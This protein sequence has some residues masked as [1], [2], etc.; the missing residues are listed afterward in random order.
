MASG[1]VLHSSQVCVG[2]GK[3]FFLPLLASLQG[4]LGH[5]TW[6]S[7]YVGSK[8]EMSYKTP[9]RPVFDPR[10]ALS[11]APVD[12]CLLGLGSFL[13]HTITWNTV[14]YLECRTTAGDDTSQGVICAPVS[15]LPSGLRTNLSFSI[16]I[17]ANLV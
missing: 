3:S 16:P 17:T 11:L 10:S 1:I 14:Q 2:R 6:L 8:V 13:P 4:A 7:V 15:S 5:L 9:T 12:T